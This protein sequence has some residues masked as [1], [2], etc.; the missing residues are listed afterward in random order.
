MEEILNKMYPIGHIYVITK[1]NTKLPK[2]GVWKYMG[3]E[4]SIIGPT[5]YYVR[6][7]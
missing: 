1:K 5:Y 7:S 6:V 2:I 4:V 3:K